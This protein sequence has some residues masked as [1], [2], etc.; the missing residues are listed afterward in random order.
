VD[1][2]TPPPQ[3][4]TGTALY[5]TESGNILINV[6]VAS[7]GQEGKS[8]NQNLEFDTL[9]TAEAGSFKW[10]HTESLYQSE[11]YDHFI[12]LFSHKFML[13]FARFLQYCCTTSNCIR[14]ISTT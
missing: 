13:L 1:Y 7:C 10:Y 9:P 2:L 14:A 5:K 4:F 12:C 6:S 11:I 8:P 3:S